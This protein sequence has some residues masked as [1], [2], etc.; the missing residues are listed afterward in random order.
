MS[1]AGLI[2]LMASLSGCN[3]LD[4]LVPQECVDMIHP[5]IEVEVRDANNGAPAARGAIG[6]VA[7][8]TNVYPLEG[9]PLAVGTS[10]VMTSFNGPG[11]Y[12][13]VVQK[14]GY[15][16]WDTSN[17]RVRA[18]GPCAVETV[19]LQAELLRVQ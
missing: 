5:G 13:V 17:I 18:D 4:A 14:E 8:G 10:L 11:T 6:F 12:S 9:V 3:V 16:D 7:S 2:L 19:R 1:R 15:Q